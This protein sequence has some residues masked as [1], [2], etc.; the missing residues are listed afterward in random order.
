MKGEAAVAI[1]AS[2]GL[3]QVAVSFQH[4]RRSFVPPSFFLFVSSSTLHEVMA[5]K[6]SIDMN[7]FTS[8]PLEKSFSNRNKEMSRNGHHAVTFDDGNTYTG[9]WRDG[10]KHGQ[11]IRT[12]ADGDKYTGAWRNGKRN[13]Q[14]IYTWAD[15]NSR[16]R[17]LHG[18]VV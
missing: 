17:H 9:A 15:G 11:G 16:W 18:R 4:A 8:V 7:F 3:A 14:G 12:W 1:L 13:G 10:K 5:G 2:E 6:M